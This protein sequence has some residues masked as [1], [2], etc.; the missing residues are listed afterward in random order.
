MSSRKYALL[1]LI[2]VLYTPVVMGDSWRDNMQYLVYSPRY[3]GP[4]A[5]PF[6][7]LRSGIAPSRFEVEVRGQYHYY[8]GDKTKDF[9]TRALLPIVKGRA[10]VEISWLVV[11]DY[12][13][14]P[15]TRDERHAVETESPISYN[16]DIVVS[17]FF[18]LLKS[19]KWVDAMLNMTL[20]TAS[21]SRVCD[22]RFTDAAAYWFDLTVGKTLLKNASQTASLRMQALAGFYCWTTNRID[23]RQNDAFSF[24]VGF[25]GTYRNFSL[26]SDLSGFHGYENNGDRPLILRNNLRYE[27]KKNIISLRYNHGMKDYLYDNYSVGFIRCF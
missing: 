8:S 12:K 26:S 15:E 16:G 19:E 24:G 25:T 21:G 4:S 27:Y 1:V 3:F 9:F 23:H 18:Q 2:T 20:K 13:L 7:E 22:A 17:V 6:P 5:F 11:E 10:G 14:T